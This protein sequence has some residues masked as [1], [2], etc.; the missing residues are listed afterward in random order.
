VAEIL[1]KGGYISLDA[2]D[3][4]IMNTPS[5]LGGGQKRTWYKSEMEPCVGTA[6]FLEVPIP[7]QQQR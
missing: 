6:L 4:Q 1:F 7:P 3:E 5:K 2:V